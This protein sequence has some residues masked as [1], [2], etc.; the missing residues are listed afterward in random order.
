MEKSRI[1]STKEWKELKLQDH[2]KNIFMEDREQDEISKILKEL[3][4]AVILKDMILDEA[5]YGQ[6]GI[7]IENNNIRLLTQEEIWRIRNI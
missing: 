2:T 6:S 7:Y 3:D 5:I 4:T 1:P